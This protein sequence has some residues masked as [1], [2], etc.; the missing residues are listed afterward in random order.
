MNRTQVADARVESNRR[1]SLEVMVSSLVVSKLFIP[2]ARRMELLTSTL[3]SSSRGL[4][5]LRNLRL[6]GSERVKIHIY[7]VVRLRNVVLALRRELSHCFRR[8]AE[9]SREQFEAQ[10]LEKPVMVCIRNSPRKKSL[11]PL[12]DQSLAS[13]Q[14]PSAQRQSVS[15]MDSIREAGAHD[16]AVDFGGV[17]I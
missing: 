12:A 2:I 16:Q 17:W 10:A 6:S 8:H 11:H 14:R 1:E 13:V 3:V 5:I 7:A 4:E 9:P 15:A